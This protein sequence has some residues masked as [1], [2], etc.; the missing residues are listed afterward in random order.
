MALDGASANLGPR[1]DAWVRN[2]ERIILELQKQNDV[3]RSQI[4]AVS[5]TR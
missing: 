3:L 5:S 1:S 2:L 4:A